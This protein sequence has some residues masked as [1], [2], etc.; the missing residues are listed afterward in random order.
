[1]FGLFMGS[2]YSIN[3]EKAG[4]TSVLRSLLSLLTALL[5][6][7]GVMNIIS[8]PQSQAHPRIRQHLDGIAYSP[9]RDAESPDIGTIVSA[10]SINRDLQILRPFLES[11]EMQ[12]RT[13]GST[14]GNQKIARIARENGISTLQGAWISKLKSENRK[15]L[16]NLIKSA[17]RGEVK[18][19]IVGNEV[20]LRGDLT[21][22]Q[23]INYIRWTK[24]RISVPV[25]TAETWQTW[26]KSPDLAAAVDVMLI[27]VH[28]Y[29]ENISVENAPDHVIN[30]YKKLKNRYPNKEIVIGETGWPSAGPRRGRSVPS[31]ANQKYFTKRFAALA[32]H[33][34]VP[35]FFFS[36]FDEKWK[37]GKEEGVG[38]YWGI[39]N[40]R[41][42]LKA[43]LQGT[44][45]RPSI[46]RLIKTINVSGEEHAVYAGPTL[47]EGYDMGVDSENRDQAWATDLIGSMRLAYP[48]GQGWGAVFITFGP[49]VNPPRPYINLSAYNTLSVDLKGANGGE[50]VKIGIKDNTDLDNGLEAKEE[51]ILTNTWQTYT[52]DLADFTTADLTK[53]YVVAE[54]VFEGATARTIEFKNVIYK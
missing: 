54:F 50:K 34:R 3:S 36:A 52:F 29:W 8:P 26:L 20:L 14:H 18:T 33:E 23:L 32:Q 4:Y 39:L 27:H 41:G 9:Y 1:M 15:Q 37:K 2:E 25:A 6:F 53:L 51:V 45:P 31:G 11:E 12:I 16:N 44:F 5:V 43:H 49:P 30:A 47:S 48:G 40:T 42:A 38:P 7:A 22:K 24:R 19:A 13:Y 46:K 28:P 35:Y 17:R 21:E 10:P